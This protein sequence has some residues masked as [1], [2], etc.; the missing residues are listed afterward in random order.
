VSTDSQASKD[1]QKDLADDTLGLAK[2]KNVHRLFFQQGETT[3]RKSYTTR[4][5]LLDRDVLWIVPGNGKGRKPG[6]EAMNGVPR[7]EIHFAALRLRRV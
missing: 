2:A 1:Y 7:L 5:A 6:G 3:A 4:Q